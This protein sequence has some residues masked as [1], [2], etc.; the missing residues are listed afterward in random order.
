MANIN[1]LNEKSPYR[2]Q[3]L[4]FIPAT[5]LRG[6]LRISFERGLGAVELE[7]VEDESGQSSPS[8]ALALS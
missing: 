2:T 4:P 1:P 8:G 3:G 6:S 7:L 5:A